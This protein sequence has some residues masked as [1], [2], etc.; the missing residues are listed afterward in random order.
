MSDVPAAASTAPPPVNGTN[1]EKHGRQSS[2]R[3]PRGAPR[4]DVAAAAIGRD[5]ANAR[6]TLPFAAAAVSAGTT[7]G[8]AA[9]AARA[10][11]SDHFI[12]S[13]QSSG[14]DIR[15][16]TNVTFGVPASISQ[17]AYEPPC[18]ATRVEEATVPAAAVGVSAGTSAAAFPQ[19]T[20]IE[21]LVRVT[22]HLTGYT[23]TTDCGSWST[24]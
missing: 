19:E 10:G 20:E 11:V 14:K 1:A 9:S 17:L 15:V 22:A 4:T 3:H 8:F 21:R 6:G 2:A 5:G 16:S 12:S 13:S 24:C 7:G 23:G 18:V